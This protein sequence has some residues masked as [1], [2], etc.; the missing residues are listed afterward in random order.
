MLFGVVVVVVVAAGRFVNMAAVF[1]TGDDVEVLVVMLAMA[2]RVCCSLP[3]PGK[4][5]RAP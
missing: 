4:A 2:M 1:E 3:K 5:L